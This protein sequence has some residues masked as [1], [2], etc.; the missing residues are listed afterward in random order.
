MHDEYIFG[1]RTG[2]MGLGIQISR[3]FVGSSINGLYPGV[4]NIF[5]YHTN[6]KSYLK[7]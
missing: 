7:S 6:L 5:H 3:L 4:A 1:R 2:F